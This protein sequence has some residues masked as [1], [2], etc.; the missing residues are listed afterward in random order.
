M[1]S[2][3]GNNIFLAEGGRGI[4][5]PSGYTHRE[6]SPKYRLPPP[7]PQP[8]LPGKP[9]ATNMLQQAMWPTLALKYS[10]RCRN[11]DSGMN[12]KFNLKTLA[13]AIPFLSRTSLRSA[14]VE[15]PP[16]MNTCIETHP[17]NKVHFPLANDA[18]SCRRVPTATACNEEAS[19]QSN[20]LIH[21]IVHW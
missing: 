4:V 5:L 15:V 1:H 19:A 9:F 13:R 20:P 3:F 2:S 17:E 16:P 8:L 18:M 10:F 11:A 7:P 14:G 6:G 21:K 12:P